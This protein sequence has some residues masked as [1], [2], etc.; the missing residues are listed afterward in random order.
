[1]V[2]RVRRISLSCS[3]NDSSSR[4]V[5]A[6]TLWFN[7][8]LPVQRRSAATGIRVDHSDSVITSESSSTVSPDNVLQ[9]RE[10]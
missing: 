6:N 4:V 5:A 8:R 7:T 3:S 2:F 1:M 10:V 9:K